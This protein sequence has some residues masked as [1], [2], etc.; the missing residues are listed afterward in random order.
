MKCTLDSWFE[1]ARR[2]TSG[3]MVDDIL[4]DWKEDKSALHTRV[5][6]LEIIIDAWK[7]VAG[8]LAEELNNLNSKMFPVSWEDASETSAAWIHY[9]NLRDKESGR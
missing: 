5:V 8:E 2:G 1:Q 9:C 4:Y 3:D 6:E 7:R